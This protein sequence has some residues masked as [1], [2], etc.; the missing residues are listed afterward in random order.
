MHAILWQFQVRAG[1]EQEFEATY[2]P[3]GVWA[4]FFH[5]A[6]GYRGTHLLRDLE[7]SGRY[8]TIDRWTTQ[9]AFECFRKQCAADYEAIDRECERLTAQEIAL[10]SFTVLSEPPPEA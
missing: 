2:G 3:T 10:G 7:I 1:L 4:Q 8:I 5:Q 9:A 6:A